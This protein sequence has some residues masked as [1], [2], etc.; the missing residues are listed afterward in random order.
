MR[1][2]LPL[3][4][5]LLTAAACA[6]QAAPV[7][8]DT[9]PAFAGNCPAL[10]CG[11]TTVLGAY[12]FWELDETGTT[13]SPSGLRITGATWNG[14]PQ[15]IDVDGFTWLRRPA[16]G[17]PLKPISGT[18]ITVASKDGKG[19][20]E[21]TIT[22][23][24][25]LPYYEDPLMTPAVPSYWVSYVQVINGRR[26]PPVD[27]C[28]KDE[29]MSLPRPAIVFQGDRYSST[30]GALIAT[31][32]AAKPWFN[33]T[34]KDDSLWKLALMRAVEAAADAT[35]QTGV[36]ERMAHLRSIR[37]DYCGDGTPYTEI[38]TQVDWINAGG[39][40]VQDTDWN[41]EAVWGP[42]GAVCLT[43][44]R[45]PD[46]DVPCADALPACEELPGD[47][48]THGTVL[49]LVNNDAP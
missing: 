35:H 8:P 39:W 2:S 23:A 45:L 43:Y 1:H 11:N 22:A 20:F 26:Q 34:C 3:V 41:P 32:D 47:W 49:T 25:T 18:T 42:D 12:P 37:A 17:G 46:I 5:S 38:G 10:I 48:R 36:P 19:L 7:A 4:L 29:G 33:I 13:Y 31:G 24:A 14:A 6:E 21:L 16:G 27:L 15:K 40:L 9:A 44:T 28:G 30:T